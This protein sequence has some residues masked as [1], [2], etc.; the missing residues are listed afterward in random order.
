MSR[1][2]FTRPNINPRWD[3]SEDMTD[4]LTGIDFDF[5]NHDKLIHFSPFKDKNGREL[6]EGD[7]IE[8][9]SGHPYT[10]IQGESGTWIIVSKRGNNRLTMYPVLAEAAEYTGS[11]YLPMEDLHA[12]DTNRR[13]GKAGA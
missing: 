6:K 4:W 2:V 8:F 10:V 12:Q 13:E 5:I 3:D 11:I 7:E 1:L 9:G